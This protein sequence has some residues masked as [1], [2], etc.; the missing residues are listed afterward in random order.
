[1]LLRSI[2]HQRAM[3]DGVGHEK[4]IVGLGITSAQATPG[5]LRL[6]C[7]SYKTINHCCLV[8]FDQNDLDR[9]AFH[10]FSGKCMLALIN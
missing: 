10:A 8:P 2:D 3:L 4:R 1:M 5:T 6:G 9:S 7:S